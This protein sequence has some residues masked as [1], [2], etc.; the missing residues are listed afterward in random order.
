MFKRLQD[1]FGKNRRTLPRGA[2]ADIS[3]LLEAAARETLGKN[4]EANLKKIQEAGGNSYDISLR[5]FTTGNLPGALL[6][7]DGLTERRSAEEIMRSLVVDSRK[8]K[9][10]LERGRGLEIAR[11][12][13]LTSD[14]LVSVDNIADLFAAISR[15][16]TAL[17]LDGSPGALIC[18][19]RSPEV[20]DVSEPNNE[21]AIRGPRD[22]FVENLQVNTSLIRL[23]LP[24]PQL[25]IET[26]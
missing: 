18:D 8:L 22:G 4:L 7:L 3:V 26:M 24:I 23:R 12:K 13:L 15:G 6:Y 9:I 1:F 21:I 16:G 5:R 10:P 25:W 19:T 11:E 17:F 14:E 20:R 2:D